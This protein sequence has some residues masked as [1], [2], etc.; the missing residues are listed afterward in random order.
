MDEQAAIALVENAANTQ[1]IYLGDDP[2]F[3]DQRGTFEILDDMN[4]C[5]PTQNVLFAFVTPA[6]RKVMDAASLLEF[7]RFCKE[8]PERS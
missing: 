1:W 2:V 4:C 7:A 5:A 6:R 3:K 8:A